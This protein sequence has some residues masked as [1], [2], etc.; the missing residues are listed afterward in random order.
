MATPATSNVL[1]SASRLVRSHSRILSCRLSCPPRPPA[2]LLNTR[3]KHSDT[4]SPPHDRK[5]I[6]RLSPRSQNTTT[7]LRRVALEAQRSR[8][9][10]IRRSHGLLR[11]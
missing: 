5:P 8:D 3:L 4:T 10:L 6:K 7:S 9:S 11:C 1:N 2:A